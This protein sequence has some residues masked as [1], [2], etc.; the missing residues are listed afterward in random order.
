MRRLLA[1]GCLLLLPLLS[2]AAQGAEGA[3]ASRLVG[4]YKDVSIGLD[5]TTA[6]IVEPA[7]LPAPQPGHVLIW[8][9]AT[10]ECGQERWGEVDT[11]A[12]ARVNVAAFEAAGRDYLV[13]TGG[14]V[15]AFGCADEAA[16]ERFVQRYES[17]RLRGLD[18]DIEGTQTPAQIEAL[19][20]SLRRVRARWPQLRLS[21]T[22]AT[23]AASDGSR[24]SLNATG[25]AV[26]AALGAA[27]LDEAVLNLMVMNYGPP[28]RRFCVPRRGRCDMGRSARQALQNVHEKYGLPYRRLAITLML[29]END[30]PS[31]ASTP[32]D[33]AAMARM[34][35]GLG[36]AGLHWWS[37]DRDQPCPPGSPRLS[38]RCHALPG[39]A[40]GRFTGILDATRR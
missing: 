27:G 18:F 38:P 30:V 32:A 7:W 37:V 24:R 31:N 3:P 17:L 35:S 34:A 19:V 4:A 26:L 2:P 21:F 16:M 39:V 36:L 29:G 25:E 22:V 8:A 10:G 9:F 20:G 33:A 13:S 6:R 11:E 28:E 23:H 5:A 40:A 14:A 12:F 1:L 15:G